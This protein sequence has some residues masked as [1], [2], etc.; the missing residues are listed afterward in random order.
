MICKRLNTES[1]NLKKI[2]V[3][4]LGLLAQTAINTSL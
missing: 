1:G 2:F 4:L 3:V